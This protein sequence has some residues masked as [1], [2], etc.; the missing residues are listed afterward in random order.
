MALDRERDV[1]RIYRGGMDNLWWQAA[2]GTGAAEPLIT[3]SSIQFASGTTPHGDLVLF[4][5]E[6]GL[7]KN[8]QL[9]LLALDGSRRLTPPLPTTSFERNGVVSPDGRWI[10]YES[11]FSGSGPFEIYVRPFPKTDGQWKV[12]MGGGTQPLWAPNGHELFYVGPPPNNALMIVHTDTDGTSWHPGTPMKFLEGYAAISPSRT[13]DVASDGRFIMIKPS[14][15][16]QTA[17]PSLKVV[18]HFDEE[19]KRVAPPSGSR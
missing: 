14:A 16:D 5:R 12:S 4:D 18:Q 1:E 19:R 10:A 2:D 7:G 6:L 8:A 9:M 11:G 15:P 13:Y 17:A 3:R